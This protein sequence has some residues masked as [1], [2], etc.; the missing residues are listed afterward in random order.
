MDIWTRKSPESREI[1]TGLRYPTTEKENTLSTQEQM[2]TIFE[3]GSE[4]REIGSA[5]ICCL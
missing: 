5:F 2:G 4:R 3:S 1:E